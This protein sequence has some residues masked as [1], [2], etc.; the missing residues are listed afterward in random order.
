MARIKG[1]DIPNNKRTV[2]ALTYIYGIGKS[3]AT[4]ICKDAGVDE[5]IRAKDL[6]NEQV[7]ALRDEVNK[8]LTEGDLRREVN[9]NIKTKMEINSYQGIR[10]TKGLPVRGQSTNRNARTRKGKGKVVANKKKN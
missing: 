5:N 6:T 10:H 2:I 3:L 4:K 9:M 7:A 8:Y 1:V